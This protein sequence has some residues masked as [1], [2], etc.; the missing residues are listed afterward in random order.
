M[1]NSGIVFERTKK[2]AVHPALE[3]DFWGFGGL[4]LGFLFDGALGG[5]LKWIFLWASFEC[6]VIWSAFKSI[7]VDSP[8]N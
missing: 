6:Q 1:V 8:G 4:G 3:L 7:S 2:A 5:V